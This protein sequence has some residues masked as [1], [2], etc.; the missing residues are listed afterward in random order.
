MK[1]WQIAAGSLGRDYAADFVRYGMAF[2]GGNE[3]IA[4]MREVEIGD[5][6][7]LKR[8]TSM[9]VVVGDVVERNGKRRG[10]DDKDWLRDFDGCRSF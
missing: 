6:V 7:L 1:Y 4:R 8:G 3:H 9:V 5:R 2:V 10:E